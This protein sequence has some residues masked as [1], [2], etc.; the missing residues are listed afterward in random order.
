MLSNLQ[1]LWHVVVSVGKDTGT[2]T[3]GPCAK[4]QEAG[5]HRPAIYRWGLLMAT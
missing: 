5:I 2:Y 4:C 1:V 3:V